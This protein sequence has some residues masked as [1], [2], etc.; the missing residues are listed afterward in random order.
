MWI[1]VFAL[2]ISEV[3]APCSSGGAGNQPDEVVSSK[4]VESIPCAARLKGTA[5]CDALRTILV[6]EF[7]AERDCLRT[8]FHYEARIRPS[9]RSLCRDPEAGGYARS[10]LALIGDS[11]DIELLLQLTPRPDKDGVDYWVYAVA[12]SLLDPTS[13]RGWR[14]LLKAARNDFDDNWAVSGAIQTLK[15]TGSSRSRRVLEECF[16]DVESRP[17]SVI[18]ALQYIDSHPQPLEDTNLERLTERVAQA[19]HEGPWRSIGAP[20][21]NQAG[22]KALADLKVGI[23]FDRL[24]Y[25]ATFHKARGLWRLRGVRET[26]QE[27]MPSPVRIRPKPIPLLPPPPPIPPQDPPLWFPR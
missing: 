26:L 20:S 13:E 22:D 7:D 23:S 4:C 17:S 12:S 25:T 21:F 5:Q 6:R 2:L 19:I 3:V 27:L 15:L 8:I 1:G 14:F 18:R 10:L 24:T 9:L 16:P 11:E